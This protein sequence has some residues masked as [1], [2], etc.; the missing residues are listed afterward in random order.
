MI[1]NPARTIGVF[2]GTVLLALSATSSR[3]QDPPSESTTQPA[4]SA[5]TQPTTAEA[6]RDEKQEAEIV[7]Q[8][9]EEA[10]EQ[11]ESELE[12]VRQEKERADQMPDG[13]SGDR[14]AFEPVRRPAIISDE[15]FAERK[16]H[17][18]K[19][20]AAYGARRSDVVDRRSAIEA[21][22]GELDAALERID[23]LT[24]AERESLAAKYDSDGEMQRGVAA[25]LWAEAEAARAP[26]AG[27]QAL[28]RELQELRDVA[29]EDVA[30]QDRTRD[31]LEQVQQLIDNQRL[32]VYAIAEQA[33]AEWQL[34]GSY[35]A[36]ADELRAAN[37]RFWS[38][39]AYIGDIGIVLLYTVGAH[40]GLNILSWMVLRIVAF[41]SRA[42]YR[43]CAQP[44][45][46]RAQ[47]LVQFA[48]SILKLLVWVV[49]IVTIL[50]AFGI[51]PGKSAGALGIIG[52]VLAGMFQQLVVD[53]V[54]GIDIAIGGHYFVGDF[55]Q[56]GA[57]SG[58]VLD[59][60][61]KYTV[62]RTPSGQVIT[63]PNSQCIPSRRFPSGYVDNYV[64]IPLAAEA[65]VATARAVIGELSVSLN[66][67]IEAIKRVPEIVGVFEESG[68]SVV[69]LLVRVLPTCDWVITQHV[70]P[71][72][73]AR[74]A[75]AD[76]AIAGEPEFTYMND[77]PTFRRLFSRQMTDRELRQTLAAEAQPTIR[78]EALPD[79]GGEAESS[80]PSPVR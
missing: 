30:V 39:Y 2:V 24:R 40:V 53:F 14:T 27:L 10:L 37:A 18:Q 57:Q 38:R 17:L 80:T 9:A 28:Q 3:A 46:K 12:S 15:A 32:I 51:E 47:T 52:L 34:G 54:K 31:A 19:V 7:R 16:V 55:V 29:P 5:T 64:D 76:I 42:W 21:V 77:V 13:L 70:I 74:L 35:T 36:A 62:L 69:R 11:A 41:V 73:K 8:L 43:E 75:V 44:T 65:N 79:D 66:R 63:V 1:R 50:A 67:R 20:R 72:V 71:Q 25:D 4:T 45:V 61:V 56:V 60:T 49:A 23:E 6:L 33:N 78:R 26:L 22:R 68:R 48:R 59:F 58:H